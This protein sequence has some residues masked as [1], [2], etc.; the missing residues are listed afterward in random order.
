[1]AELQ[2]AQ[3]CAWNWLIDAY[4]GLACMR[5]MLKQPYVGSQSHETDACGYCAV[6]TNTLLPFS[7]HHV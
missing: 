1:M 7:G 5:S 4:A 3:V 2:E 6:L